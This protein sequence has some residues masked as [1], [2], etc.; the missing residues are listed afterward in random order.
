ME[1]TLLGMRSIALSQTFDL[2]GEASWDAAEAYAPPVVEALLRTPDWP[3]DT[4][5]NVN[6]PDVP[7][8]SV[9]GVRV[10]AQGQRPPGSF[11][12]DARVDARRVPY[13]WVKLSYQDGG[14]HPETDL[15]AIHE[16]AVS[17]TP[18]QLD[19]TNHAWRPRLEDALRNAT[20]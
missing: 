2:G 18:V 8:E 20:G 17:V 19:L 13:F 4:L 9:A 7:A 15:H 14:K 10:T 11:T 5:V 6:F 12:I 3:A 1:G 16:N